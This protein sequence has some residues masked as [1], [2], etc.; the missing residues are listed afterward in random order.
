[1]LNLLAL[2][3]LV[4][5]SGHVGHWKMSTMKQR[6]KQVTDLLLDIIWVIT[7]VG[8]IY[9]ILKDFVEGTLFG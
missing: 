7:V 5:Q 4:S 8:G 3:E 1:M 2:R 9:L 6:A